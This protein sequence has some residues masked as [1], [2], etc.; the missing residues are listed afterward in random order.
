MN[1]LR[2]HVQ[3]AGT[4]PDLVLIHG[5]SGNLRDVSFDLMD[6]LTPQYRVLAFD[7]RF[8]LKAVNGAAHTLLKEDWVGLLSEPLEAWPRQEQ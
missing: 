5:A 7:R 8:V 2:V 1:G 6:R 3:V 4:G